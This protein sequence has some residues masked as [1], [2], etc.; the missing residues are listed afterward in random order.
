MTNSKVTISRWLQIF[1]LKNVLL[2]Q[3]VK[4]YTKLWVPNV[5]GFFGLKFTRFDFSINFGV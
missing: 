4:T 1:Y 3:F 5:K 2:T